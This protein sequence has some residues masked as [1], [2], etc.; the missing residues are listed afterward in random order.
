[1]RITRGKH[2]ILKHSLRVC[3]SHGENTIYLNT[4]S[5]YVYHTGK[6]LLKIASVYAYHSGKTLLKIASVYVYHTGK[7][8]LKHSLRVCVSRGGKHYLNTASMY[9][10]HTGKNTTQRSYNYITQPPYAYH[11]GKTP[12]SPVILGGGGGIT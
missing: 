11:M 1:M 5:V 12:G 10:Y 7:M 6:T 4:A 8:L 3:V 2:Y 9:A